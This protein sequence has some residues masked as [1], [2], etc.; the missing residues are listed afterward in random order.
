MI[1]HKATKDAVEHFR[2]VWPKGCHYIAIV[3][4][5]FAVVPKDSGAWLPLKTVCI[6]KQQFEDYVREAKMEKQ[7]KSVPVTDMDI[8]DLG[9][10]VASGG[11]YYDIEGSKLYIS[12]SHDLCSARWTQSAIAPMLENGEITTRQPLP[13]YEVEG[14]F[15]EPKMCSCLGVD[16]PIFMIE[17]DDRGWLKDVEGNDWPVDH[18]TPLAPSEAAM[19]GVG[20]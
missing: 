19:Y 3:N 16:M 1:K 13:W 7:Y 20:E 17:H 8:W 15:D 5:A 11:E 2:G 10:A 12:R 6:F 14:V 4:G 9:K 18:C